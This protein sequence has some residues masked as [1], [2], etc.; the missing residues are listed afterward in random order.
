[1]TNPTPTSQRLLML[2]KPKGYVVTRSD[3]K[4]R[5]TV[6][7]LLPEWAYQDNWKPVGRLDLDSK[8]LLLFTRNAKLADQIAKPGSCRKTYEVWVRGLVT[9][10]HIKQAMKGVENSGEILKAYQVSIEGGAG[11]KT[12]LQ[13]VLD[14]GKNR[15]IRRLFG[16]LKDAKFKTA[17][18]VLDLKRIRIGGL[19]LDVESGKWRFLTSDDELLLV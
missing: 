17:L 10:D 2:N 5:K 18:K 3:E 19:N 15:H 16:S 14:E 12:K 8:G 11:H 4:D 13:V 6:Y 7:A 1:M 9:Q